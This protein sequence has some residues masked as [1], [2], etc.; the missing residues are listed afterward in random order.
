M[1]NS[2]WP[3]APKIMLNC[4]VTG[5][6]KILFHTCSSRGQQGK[7]EKHPFYSV[8][9]AR[10]RHGVKAGKREMAGIKIDIEAFKKK[11]NVMSI[12]SKEPK[13]TLLLC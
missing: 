5:E 3:A 2:V 1:S 8:L 12:K 11:M 7:D 13:Q 9:R 6:K 10:L 4:A